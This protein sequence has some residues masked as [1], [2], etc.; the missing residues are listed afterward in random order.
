GRQ[1]VRVTFETDPAEV[2]PWLVDN[3]IDYVLLDRLDSQVEDTRIRMLAT[4]LEYSD[5]FADMFSSFL[6]DRVARFSPDVDEIAA[7]R[8]EKAAYQRKLLHK[9]GRDDD[10]AAPDEAGAEDDTE[11]DR[12]EE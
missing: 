4:Q 2:Y 11:D 3:E 7:H 10:P 5:H 6:G 8:A 1:A 9:R 12:G